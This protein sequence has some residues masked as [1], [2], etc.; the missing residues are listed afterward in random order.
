MTFEAIRRDVD[1]NTGRT[2][3][4]ASAACVRNGCAATVLAGTLVAV[5]PGLFDGVHRLAVCVPAERTRSC[6]AAERLDALPAHR[7]KQVAACRSRIPDVVG[8]CWKYNS[9]SGV[10][11]QREGTR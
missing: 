4:S 1:R 7:I 10:Q 8:V 9:V 5:G 6:S 11:R 3:P 2:A